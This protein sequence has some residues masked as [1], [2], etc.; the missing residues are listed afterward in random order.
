MDC[1]NRN[2]ETNKKLAITKNPLKSN[3]LC[4]SG[5]FISGAPK[6]GGEAVCQVD[7]QTNMENVI[8]LWLGPDSHSPMLG[9]EM[10][11]GTG[12][13]GCFLDF[14]DYATKSSVCTM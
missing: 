3:Y 10:L 14:Y 7:R 1:N 12:R 4:C 11:A 5:N 13:F 6:V 9:F 2:S 8:R